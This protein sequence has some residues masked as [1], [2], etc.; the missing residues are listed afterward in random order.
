MRRF[1]IAED[2][3]VTRRGV[4]EILH[5]AFGDI[6]VGEAENVESLQA[7]LGHGR[8][9]LILLDIFMPGGTF[10][11]VLHLVRSIDGTV[12]VLVITA[13]TELEYVVQSMRA[14]ANG[15]VHKHMAADE[16]VEAIRRVAEGGT[17]LHAETAAA[18]ARSL[19][20][21]G[22]TPL[23]SLHAKLSERELE[24]FRRLARGRAVKEIAGDLGIS[25]KTVATYLARIREKTGL[26][27]HVEI[28]RYALQN[29]LVD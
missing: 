14:G 10:M 4:R 1:L 13:A 8:W 20:G 16:L 7:Q 26:M 27:S 3:S 21:G 5:D 19:Q 6:E 11:D 18:I 12:P 9:D 24:V 22:Q 17:Y 28:T 2:H 25:D 29:G 23:E 15:L